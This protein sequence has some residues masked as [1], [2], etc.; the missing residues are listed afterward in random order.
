MSKPL[1]GVAGLSFILFEQVGS[2]SQA[3]GWRFIKSG[4]LPLAREQ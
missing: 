2:S 4:L 1:S 3:F